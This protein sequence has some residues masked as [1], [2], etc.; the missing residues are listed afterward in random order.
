VKL[1][2]GETEALAGVV[3]DAGE[4]EH[5]VAVLAEEGAGQGPEDA[6]AA[7]FL[8]SQAAEVAVENKRRL[9]VGAAAAR[10][11]GQVLGRHEVEAR[12]KRGGG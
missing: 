10:G 7:R 5:V 3:A 12:G 4:A 2:A 6:A 1:A 11:R 9:V 8:A